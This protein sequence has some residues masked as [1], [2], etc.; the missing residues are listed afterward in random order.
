MFIELFVSEELSISIPDIPDMPPDPEVAV[1]VIMVIN[2]DD[3]LDIVTLGIGML[4]IAILDALD[5]L[6][7]EELDIA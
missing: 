4:V 6:G 2:S 3:E 5:I 7:I 1:E